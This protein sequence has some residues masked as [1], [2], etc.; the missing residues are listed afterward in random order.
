MQY[1]VQRLNSQFDILPNVRLELYLFS[2]VV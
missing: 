2:R 1:A